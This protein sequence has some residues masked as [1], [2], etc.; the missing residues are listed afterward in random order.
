MILL[1]FDVV[2][3]GVEMRLANAEHSVAIL[4]MKILRCARESLDELR[5]IFLHDLDDL[6]RR[7]FLC[8]IAEDVNVV[9]NSADCD[10]LA[11]QVLENRGHIGMHTRAVFIRQPGLAIK[12]REDEVS[13]EVVKRNR[14]W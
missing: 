12:R 11:F 9:R 2:P 6:H 4:P 7:V 8:E 3:D 5:R 13:T 1:S 14:H 10:R